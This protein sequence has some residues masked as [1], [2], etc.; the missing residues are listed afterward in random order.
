M[1]LLGNYDFLGLP[2]TSQHNAKQR[3]APDLISLYTY[4]IRANSRHS[5]IHLEAAGECD[6]GAGS[7]VAKPTR[8]IG[9][10]RTP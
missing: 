2:R 9:L 6:N 5:R 4:L 1:I 8:K 10:P 3:Q 7:G